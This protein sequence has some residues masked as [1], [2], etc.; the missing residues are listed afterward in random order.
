MGLAQNTYHEDPTGVVQAEARNCVFDKFDKACE[1]DMEGRFVEA[2]ELYT[3]IIGIDPNHVESYH[4]RGCNFLMLER[5]DDAERDHLRCVE[6]VPDSSDAHMQLAESVLE[7]PDLTEERLRVALEH[8]KT[9]DKLDSY[10][11]AYALKHVPAGIAAYV[12][13]RLGDY[14]EAARMQEEGLRIAEQMPEYL[15]G[16]DLEKYRIQLVAYRRNELPE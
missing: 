10:S 1:L 4:N 14:E 7:R 8:A 11:S 6:L 2:N 12:H 16:P 5:W 9:A 15:V 3:E 13:A